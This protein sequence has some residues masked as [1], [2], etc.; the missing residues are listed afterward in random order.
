MLRWKT[1]SAICAMML[2]ACP[3]TSFAQ[4]IV[5]PAPPEVSILQPM[6]PIKIPGQIRKVAYAPLVPLVT[7]QQAVAANPTLQPPG[8]TQPVAYPAATQPVLAA[9]FAAQRVAAQPVATQPVATQ[10][11]ATQPVVATQH[12][13]T[14]PVATQPVAT[15]PV[16][17][18]PVATLPVATPQVRTA[19]LSPLAPI[20]PIQLRNNPT[21]PAHTQ[22][23]SATYRP[24]SGAQQPVDRAASPKII[25]RTPFVQPHNPNLYLFVVENVGA[26]D[27]TN[28]TV[29]LYVPQGVTITNVVP[30]SASN[31]TQRAHVNLT[32]LRAGSKSIIEV[33]VSPT[34]NVVE[35]QT[36][37]ALESVHMFSTAANPN[38]VVRSR[39][40]APISTPVA[41]Q[42]A[43]PLAPLTEVVSAIPLETVAAP[44]QTVPVTQVSQVKSPLQPLT[45]IAASTPVAA[46]PAVATPPATAAAITSPIAETTA[47]TGRAQPPNMANA[48][49][50]NANQV[51]A[52]LASATSVAAQ[53]SADAHLTATVDGPV[54][55]DTNQEANFSITVTNPNQTEASSIIVQLSVPAGLKITVLDRDAWFDQENQTISWEISQLGSGQQELIQYKAVGQA[56]GQK[57]QKV[58]IGMENVYQGKAQLV[59]LVSN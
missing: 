6:G 18:L 21:A 1:P 46:I 11:V 5:K 44:R 56:V 42:L 8:G 22:T 20:P 38:H 14:L 13:A 40:Q 9:P 15:Q 31:S 54:T 27:A 41:T 28:A 33:E 4:Q 49:L 12:V 55:L 17:T 50:N 24:P 29:D 10:P 26:V 19:A 34:T 2:T 58:T 59:T 16:A 36:R 30:A 32:D 35:F 7:P 37:L 51:Q 48:A 25:I 57:N 52:Q 23:L 53:V 39:L 43:V 3:L 47:R 45:P